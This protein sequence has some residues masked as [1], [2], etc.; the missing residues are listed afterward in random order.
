MSAYQPLKR[1]VI[2]FPFLVLSVV[3][4]IGTYYLVQ[5]FIH[6]MGPVTNINGGYAWGIWVVYDVVVGTALACGGFA[7]AITV[8]VMNKGKYSPLIRP[9]ILASL[10]G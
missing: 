3:A 1:P 10:L 7:R 5:R 9:A 2:T 6:G 8:Y 4:L